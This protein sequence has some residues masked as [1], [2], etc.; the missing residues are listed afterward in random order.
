VGRVIAGLIIFISI[1]PSAHGAETTIEAESLRSDRSAGYSVTSSTTNASVKYLRYFDRGSYACYDD[2]DL[3]GVKSIEVHY[4]KGESE[5]RRFAI[6]V[7]DEREPG[8]RTN[9]GEKITRSTGGWETFRPHRVG[10]SEP[11]D[12]RRRLCIVGLEGGGVFNLDK[13]TLSAVAAQNDGITQ[14]F[15]D[16]RQVM[17]AGGHSF[18]LEKIGDAPGE[19]YAMDFLANDLLVATQKSGSLWLFRNG[20][21]QGPVQGTPKVWFSGQG[22][23]LSVRAHPDYSKNGWLYLTYADPSSDGGITRVVRGQLKELNWVNEQTIYLSPAELHTPSG[24][25]FGAAL[26]FLGN[27]L[28]F[29][30][31]ERGERQLAQDLSD[32]RGKIHRVHADGSIPQDN[33]FIAN[34]QA[35]PSIWSYGHRNPQG[36]TVHPRTGEL[37]SAEHGPMGGDEINLIR[38][39]RNYG[40]PV[41]TFGKNYD[42]TVISDATEK[43]GFES[44]RHHWTPSIGVSAIQFYTGTRFPK[45]RDRLLVASLARQELHLLSIESGRV[46]KDEVLLKDMGRIRDIRVGSDG[47]PYVILNTL[48]GAIYRLVPQPPKL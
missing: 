10:L 11:V 27:D 8:K 5:P 46:T 26:A 6:V 31:G 28:Y 34:K 43:E 4:A 33:P 23:L 9:L 29:S 19:L 37:W 39:G 22:G 20:T 25:H 47:Y 2:I 36:L 35:V 14:T 38:R 16:S 15:G 32:P 13:F 45:W 3:T 41:V 17:A 48:T 24:E 30:I 42:G 21:R 12:G 1:A 18:T 44:P 40:W 7:T